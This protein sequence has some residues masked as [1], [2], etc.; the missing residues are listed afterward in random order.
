MQTMNIVCR[1]VNS[2]FLFVSF[3]YPVVCRLDADSTRI[4]K[5]FGPCSRR[6]VSGYFFGDLKGYAT[7]NSTFS[8]YFF[9]KTY[10]AQIILSI[11]IGI[12]DFNLDS[13]KRWKIYIFCKF[14]IWNVVEISPEFRY[15]DFRNNFIKKKK[16]KCIFRSK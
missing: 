6:I 12:I 15:N 8:R 11:S 1:D 9:K 5:Y 16:M 13:T 7:W 14:L 10:S 4:V 3:F 2:S